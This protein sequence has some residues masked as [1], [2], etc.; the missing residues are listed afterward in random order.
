MDMA[1]QYDHYLLQKKVFALTGILRIYNPQDQ[2]VLYCQQKFL[3]LKE[4]IRIYS[5]ESKI[6]ELLNIQARQIIDFSAYYD[7]FDSQ[8]ST[9]VGG[10]RRKGFRSIIQD[11][12]EV[13]DPQEQLIGVLREDSLNQA[14]LRRFLLGRL[15]PQNYNLNIGTNRVADYKQR[16]HLFRYELDIDF[17]MDA[18]KKLDHRLGIAAA[19]L[20]AII[21]G[22][23]HSQS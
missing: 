16:F 11:E 4:D 7:V 21:E 3:K 8:Y 19:I 14:L 9:K 23:Q 15:L 2:L 10:L 17:Q 1:F 12:W 6:R 13:F 18:V 20:L 22:R 5:D